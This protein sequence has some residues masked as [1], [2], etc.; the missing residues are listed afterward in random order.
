MSTPDFARAR[1]IKSRHSEPNR[2]CVELA[3]LDGML[4]IRD[5][6]NPDRNLVLLFTPSSAA[7]FLATLRRGT[8]DHH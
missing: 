6:K 8:L 4:G 1:W 7:T 5:S 2:S 3:Y